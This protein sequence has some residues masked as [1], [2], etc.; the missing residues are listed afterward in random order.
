MDLEN[1]QD[2]D[3]EDI[4]KEFGE[5]PESEEPSEPTGRMP[6]L[7]LDEEA[8]DMPEELSAREIPAQ[9]WAKFTCTGPLP[10]AL[11][12]VNTVTLN[13]LQVAK[14]VR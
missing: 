9:T 10:G 1:N 7:R 11:Q 3:L 4:L 14:G 5:P 12:S 6:E 13:Q 2:F 8:A